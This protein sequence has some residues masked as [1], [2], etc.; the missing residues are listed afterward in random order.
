LAK[1]EPELCKKEEERNYISF[2][3]IKDPKSQTEA[4]LTAY[5]HRKKGMTK[6]LNTDIF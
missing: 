6:E 1:G 4:T 3:H 2:R 5:F